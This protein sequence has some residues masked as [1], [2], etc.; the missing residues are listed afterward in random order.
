MRPGKPS[1][2]A[3]WVA[4]WRG[5]ATWIQR[6]IVADP[7]A[8]ALV[9]AP[10]AQLLS[11]ARRSPRAVTAVNDF[12]ALVSGGRSLHMMLRTRAIDDAILF[13]VSEGAR[14]LVIVGAGLDARAWR[15]AELSTCTVFEVDHPATQAYKRPRVEGLPP[16]AREIRFVGADL[17]HDDVAA[18]LRDAGH[19]PAEPTLFL[20]E[21]LTMYLTERAIGSA[22]AAMRRSGTVGSTLLATYFE[23]VGSPFSR[24]LSAVLGTVREPVRSAFS[25]GEMQR[26]LEGAGF[27]VTS[28][29]GDP[30]WSPRYLGRPQRWSLERLVR[31]TPLG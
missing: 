19:A 10:Y 21:G 24:A 2:T 25:P 4:A 7:V 26:T 5:A 14:Q 30:E 31:A 15:L 12:A 9:P 20:L 11:A 23:R 16:C 22:L 27:A 29:E 1:L 3:T 28:D 18:A 8:E 13:A 17:E 6:S